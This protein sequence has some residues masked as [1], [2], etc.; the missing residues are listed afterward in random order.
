LKV[1][2]NFDDLGV[3]GLLVMWATTFILGVCVISW[4]KLSKT[5]DLC[6]NPGPRK[7]KKFTE[8]ALGF[9]QKSY[10]FEPKKVPGA[11][12]FGP[13]PSLKQCIGVVDN[14]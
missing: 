2:S 1:K 6:K 14:F 8:M 13:G 5:Y 3:A 12:R 4:K 9:F 10:F 7:G 11:T